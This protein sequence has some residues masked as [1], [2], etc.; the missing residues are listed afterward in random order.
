MTENKI[1]LHKYAMLFGTYMGIF[2]IA[3][4]ILFPAGFR[5]PLCSLLFMALTAA[6][7]VV[8]YLYTRSYRN[9]VCGGHIKF[10]HAVLFNIFMYMFAALLAAVAHYAYFQFIDQGFIIDTYEQL[11]EEAFAQQTIDLTAENKEMIRNMIA[12]ARTLT[13]I[14]ITMQLI[15]WDIIWGSILSI[16]TALLVMRRE[17]H[18]ASMS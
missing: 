10:A 6:V 1:Y 3:K 13:P 2:W 12:N 9:R 18:P 14:D 15:S 16:P 8:G 5:L 11:W 17:R 4:F 7:P